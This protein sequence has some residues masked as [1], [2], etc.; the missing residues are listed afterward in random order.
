MCESCRGLLAGL[1]SHYFSLLS[2]GGYFSL[3]SFHHFPFPTSLFPPLQL[4]GGS[5]EIL[6]FAYLCTRPFQGRAPRGR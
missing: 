4:L 6:I 1:P 2:E 3:V 5:G